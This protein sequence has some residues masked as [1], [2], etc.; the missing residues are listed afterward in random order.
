M[1]S[2]HC[3]GLRLAPTTPNRRVHSHNLGIQSFTTNSQSAQ[4]NINRSPPTQSHQSRCISRATF[5]H[6]LQVPSLT[7][8]LSHVQPSSRSA[9]SIPALSNGFVRHAVRHSWPLLVLVVIACMAQGP[10]V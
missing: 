4:C 6:W 9:A 7:L 1:M 5:F 3:Q 10:G 8:S 2:S